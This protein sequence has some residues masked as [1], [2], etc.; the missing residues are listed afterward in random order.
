MA[1]D[2]CIKGDLDQLKTFG[3]V[4]DLLNDQK[5][6]IL[7]TAVR[8]GHLPIVDYL[9]DRFPQMSIG[10]DARGRTPLHIAVENLDVTLVEKFVC[11]STELIL[12]RDR[13]FCSPL[14]HALLM[15]FWQAVVLMLSHQPKITFQTTSGGHTLFHDAVYGNNVT[16]MRYL[17]TVC[18]PSLLKTKDDLGLTPLHLAVERGFMDMVQLIV[19]KDSTTVDVQDTN[20]G[21][22]PIFGVNDVTVLTYFHQ[23]FPHV[24]QQKSKFGNQ[25]LLY[26]LCGKF[27]TCSEVIDTLLR[28]CPDLLHEL[29]TDGK[30]PLHNAFYRKSQKAVN[31]I[32]R[33]E[34]DIMANCKSTDEFG[35]T[36]LHMVVEMYCDVDMVLAVFQSCPSNLYLPNKDG[37]TPLHLAIETK[38]PAVV[39]LFQPYLTI[40]MMVALRDS[41]LKRCGIDLLSVQSVP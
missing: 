4:S 11:F 36:S 5:E 16:M 22:T 30:S 35:N 17:F 24:L 34:P 14:R 23:R 38:N 21:Y 2:V 32:L 39:D 19:D 29:T 40:D 8:F 18:P 12:I 28:L 25:T 33:F 37:D 10:T 41:C 26:H 9:L 27:T 15:G 20:D 3:D 7:H 13:E 31:A 1:H 6:S